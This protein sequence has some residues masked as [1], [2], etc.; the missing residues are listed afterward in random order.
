MK[1]VVSSSE[2]LYHLQA[3]SRVVSSKSTIPILENIL[4]ELS[5]DKLTITASDLESTMVTSMPLENIEGT[6]VI[7][8]P[9]KILLET[10]KK[11][12]EQPITFDISDDTKKVDIVTDKG[13]FSVVGLDGDEFP[14]IPQIDA[15]KSS[16]LNLPA[17]LVL[18]GINK[19]LFATADDELRPVMNGILIEMSPE[20][21]TFVA[22]DSHKLV[23]YQRSDATTE[24]SS[25]FILPKK[26]ASFLKSVL[27]KEEGDVLIEFDDK[28]AFFQMENHR[29][30]CRLVEGNYPSYNAVIPQDNPNKV[31]IDRQEV[32]NS[33]GR[34]SLF[35]NQASNLV[36]LSI[37]GD[38]L[39]VSAQDI[40]FSISAYEKLSCQYEGEPIEIGFKSAFLAEL[41]DN[42]STDDVVMEL[43]DP[44]RA[45]IFLPTENDG[46][47]DELMLLMPMMINA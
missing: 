13:K 26:P 37:K 35:S 40:D 1:F 32:V 36:K 23:R 47:E 43:A 45:G 21:L 24:F 11:F 22:S 10:L 42:V 25:S 16:R 6:G 8:L 28:N 27:V 46:P 44:A 14:E 31:I 34:V 20:N 4:F 39:M 33:L 15:D 5:E 38:E 9:A 12:P 29:L 41:L 17:S 19:T 30:V 2:I 18:S 7:A 3:V